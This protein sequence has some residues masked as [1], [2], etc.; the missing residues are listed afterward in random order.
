LEI[1][2]KEGASKKDWEG[3]CREWTENQRMCWHSSQER[4]GGEVCQIPL[5][6]GEAWRQMGDYSILHHGINNSL[7]KTLPTS[8]EEKRKLT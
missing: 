8:L 6:D 5:K 4:M 2:Q 3:M 1:K 7:D